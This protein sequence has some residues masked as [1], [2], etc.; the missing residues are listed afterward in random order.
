MRARLRVGESVSA[1]SFAI[2]IRESCR[3]CFEETE[4]RRYRPTIR[5]LSLLL[6][7]ILL[8]VS[9]S[10]FVCAR[11]DVSRG[12]TRPSQALSHAFIV[13]RNMLEMRDCACRK[14]VEAAQPRCVRVRFSRLRDG[15]C[16]R[17]L[18]EYTIFGEYF[19]V[20]CFFFSKV[21]RI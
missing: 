1:A 4:D 11:V 2:V 6:P 8:S 18:G 5:H 9:L 17:L 7:Y 21:M 16:R 3:G 10:H 12:L 13:A 19:T 14:Y 15:F 20:L